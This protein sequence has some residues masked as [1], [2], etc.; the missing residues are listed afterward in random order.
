MS[1]KN[2]IDFL[3]FGTII[4]LA[5]KEYYRPKYGYINYFKLFYFFFIPQKIFRINS[6]AKWP[7]HFTSTIH[8]IERISK[9]ILCDPADSPGVLIN[10]RNGV[11]FGSYIEIGPGT[12]ILSSTDNK[13]NKNPIEIS[14]NVWIGANCTIMPE[15]TIGENV[16]IGAGSVVTENIPSDSVA[17]GNPCK[18]IKSKIKYNAQLDK[19]NFNRPIP[20]NYREFLR[21]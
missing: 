6:K 14:N 13:T 2:K 18:V 5:F 15:V 20:K 9:G 16:I 3:I 8:F 12:K 17:V 21:A 19:I 11:N 10:A 4:N 1:L 7:V